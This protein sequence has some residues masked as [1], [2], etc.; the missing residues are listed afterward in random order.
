MAVVT[1]AVV[2]IVVTSGGSSGGLSQSE[3]NPT[4]TGP[5]SGYNV[6]D[7]RNTQVATA[8]IEG[9]LYNEARAADRSLGLQSMS[10]AGPLKDLS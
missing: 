4:Y 2:V 8:E 3:A 10:S 7:P 9:V 6:T 1:V 5:L